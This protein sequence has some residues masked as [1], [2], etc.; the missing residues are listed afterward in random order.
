M[1]SA[2]DKRNEM[3][4]RNVFIAIAVLPMVFGLQHAEAA[5]CQ[6]EV[7]RVDPVTSEK[8]TQTK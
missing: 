2:E 1:R 3:K 7:Q 8:Y 6:Y 4:K 5:A